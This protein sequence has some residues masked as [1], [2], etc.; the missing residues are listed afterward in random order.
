MTLLIGTGCQKD[1]ATG[2]RPQVLTV[3]GQDEVV[4]QHAVAYQLLVEE[5]ER[6]RATSGP[7]PHE[8]CQ[9]GRA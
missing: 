9:Q 8:Q 3:N 1:G 4:V 7:A 5:L 2:T 6:A